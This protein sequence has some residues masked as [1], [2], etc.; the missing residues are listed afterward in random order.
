MRKPAMC[1]Q[2]RCAEAGD[3]FRGDGMIGRACAARRSIRQADQVNIRLLC[4]ARR[5]SRSGTTSHNGPIM[6]CCADGLFC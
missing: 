4:L 1:E 6:R 3:A 5:A 2:Q